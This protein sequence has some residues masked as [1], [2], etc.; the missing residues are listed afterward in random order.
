MLL[1]QVR[2]RHF[3]LE[4]DATLA[5]P[6]RC[7][8]RFVFGPK[9]P[10]GEEVGGGRTVVQGGGG[11][12]YF[13]ANNGYFHFVSERG[14]DP[15]DVQ[16]NEA[17]ARFVTLRGSE[18]TIE[19]ECESL[20]ELGQLVEAV[21]YLFPSL[22]AVSFADPPYVERVY[23]RVGEVPFRWEL[24]EIT[25]PLRTTNQQEQERAVIRA[26][27]DFHELLPL[28]N[29]RLAGALHY[30]HVALRLGRAAQVAGEFLPEFLLN[31][32]K[33]LEVLFHPGK[34]DDV[35][36][37]LAS[38]GFER[39][40]GEKFI[41]PAMALRNELDVG[42]ASLAVF[43]QAQ[44]QAVHAYA[45]Q[46]EERFREMFTRV[47]ERFREGIFVPAPYDDVKPSE[48]AVRLIE[49]LREVFAP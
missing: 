42:H 10:F 46:A 9:Q 35:R 36:A 7:E 12:V 22:L 13:N 38:L 1:Y 23:G 15:L 31:L 5:W 28:S 6:C 45:E 2:G 4:R 14:L 41:L 21:Y 44:L 33:S 3:R 19:Q 27:K 39:D 20:N 11:P 17:D 37:G 29:R 30:F 34:R 40:W 32:T 48:S 18:L 25:M 24:A 43:S 8:A 26:W 16:I 47:L 49:R